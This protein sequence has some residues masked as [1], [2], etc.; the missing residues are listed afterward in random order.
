MEEASADLPA[1]HRLVLMAAR[2]LLTLRHPVLVARFAMRLGYLPN[3]AAPT[4]Y[5]EL[6]LW[7]KI[8]DH[9]PLFVTLTDKLAAKAH[10]RA[11]CPELPVPETLWSGSNPED[12]PAA[13][14]AGQ[15]VVKTNHGCEMNLFV[16]DGQ[17]GRAEIVRKTRR[18]L[19]KRFG[20]RS[21]E[22]AYWPI[23]P[24]V[25]VEERLKL[26]G[27]TIATDI[28]VHVCSG[29]IS[30]VWAEDKLAER[31][32]LFD[33]DGRPLPGRDPDYPREDQFLPVGPALLDLVRQA[34]ALAPHIAGDLD[35]ARI[36]FLV[37]DKGLY[38]GEIC[39]YSAAGYGTWTN[40][41]I[42]EQLARLWRLEDSAY[43]RRRH[44]GVSRFYAE[45]LRARCAMRGTDN[46]DG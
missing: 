11:A 14:L 25:L 41:A 15:V 44:R 9:N 36:D 16:S 34:I 12:I 45:A 21:G 26:S 32:H 17:P 5:N 2:I 40:P 4:R 28:K 19:T 20:R 6:M 1:R 31:S 13:L 23:A 22:W 18:W 27:R 35:H 7:R 33:G 10:I 43:L 30:H 24:V 37:T 8:V 29:D 46:F 38:A 3:P 42:A 39:I